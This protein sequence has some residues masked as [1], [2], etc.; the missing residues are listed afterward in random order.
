M[1]ESTNL[2]PSIDFVRRVMDLPDKELSY[3]KYLSFIKDFGT[4]YVSEA[5]L[6]GVFK[7]IQEFSKFVTKVIKTMD[8]VVTYIEIS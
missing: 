5:N 6:G 1:Q 7:Q 4:H 3:D 2:I 8:T